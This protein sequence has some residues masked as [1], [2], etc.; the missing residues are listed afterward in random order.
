MSAQL[1][2][3]GPPQE[4]CGTAG[5][6]AT[7]PSHSLELAWDMAQTVALFFF[8]NKVNEIG[9]WGD[10][11]NTLYLHIFLI[12]FWEREWLNFISKQGH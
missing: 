9:W 7:R 11:G 6:S 8:F 3:G 4:A 1:T 2:P 10:V 5:Q 12:K